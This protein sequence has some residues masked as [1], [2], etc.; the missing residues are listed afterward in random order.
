[1]KKYLIAGDWKH[2]MYEYAWALSLKANNIHVIK[3]SW[4]SSYKNLITRAQVKYS[5][6]FFFTF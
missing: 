5:L 1:M 3:Y 4:I 6:P 2:Q